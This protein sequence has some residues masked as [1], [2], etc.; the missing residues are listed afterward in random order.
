VF[1]KIVKE[2]FSETKN[3]ASPQL[4]KQGGTNDQNDPGRCE[5]EA[6]NA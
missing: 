1:A 4:K 3:T 6:A 5:D 2:N